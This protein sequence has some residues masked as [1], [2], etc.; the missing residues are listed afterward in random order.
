MLV[1]PDILV[2]Y[3]QSLDAIGTR[4]CHQMKKILSK[5]QVEGR[6]R[7]SPYPSKCF[8]LRN[9]TRENQTSLLGSFHKPLRGGYSWRR[10][11][12]ISQPK[13][14][15]VTRRWVRSMNIVE[16]SV[17]T[18]PI[19]V[20]KKGNLRPELA[21]LEYFLHHCDF[22]GLM[23]QISIS[24]R[25]IIRCTSYWPNFLVHLRPYYTYDTPNMTFFKAQFVI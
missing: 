23:S 6:W 11:A 24:Q 19:I 20:K 16:G 12:L 9:P 8:S 4:F 13:K 22:C 3:S 25:L 15:L 2:V 18:D 5:G 10:W 17:T 21:I 14:I 1:R 7:A